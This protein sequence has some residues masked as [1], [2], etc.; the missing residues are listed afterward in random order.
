MTPTT[1]KQ[2]GGTFLGLIIGLV[3]GLVIA[4]VVALIITKAPIPFLNKGAQPE[5]SA[6]PNAS[7]LEDPN[8]SMYG[9]KEV[10]KEAARDFARDPAVAAKLE[11]GK[12]ALAKPADISPVAPAQGASPPVS[13]SPNDER[14]NYFLQAGAYRETADAEATRAKLALL[15]VEASISERPSDNGTLYRVRVGPFGQI[16]AMNKVRARLADNGM[17]VAVIRITK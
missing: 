11:E 13:A 16:D 14:Y 2:T 1:S 10:A 9:N 4:V 17:D 3:I 8:K 6:V 7:Q 15:G 12:P 5:K